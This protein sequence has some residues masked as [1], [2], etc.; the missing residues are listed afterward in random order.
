MVIRTALFLLQAV[1]RALDTM[2]NFTDNTVNRFY[3]SGSSEVYN[4]CNVLQNFTFN[5]RSH[6]PFYLMAI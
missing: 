2:E 1:V 5:V 4:I 6:L 3:V